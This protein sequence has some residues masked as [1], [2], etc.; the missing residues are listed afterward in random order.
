MPPVH[1]AACHSVEIEQCLQRFF[2]TFLF[3]TRKQNVIYLRPPCRCR[4]ESAR[5]GCGGRQHAHKIKCLGLSVHIRRNNITKRRAYPFGQY[6][7]VEPPARHFT[8]I[9]LS[10]CTHACKHT[11]N[12]LKTW[13]GSAALAAF[14]PV[15]VQF[16][17]LILLSTLRGSSSGGDGTH[18]HD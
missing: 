10:L 13:F 18:G 8:L 14:S 1:C 9:S 7:L 15:Q 4:F 2:L 11:H 5:L 17:S 6:C 3:L 16:S 12:F